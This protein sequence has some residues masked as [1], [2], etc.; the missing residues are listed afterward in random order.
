M[1]ILAELYSMADSSTTAGCIPILFSWRLLGSFSASQRYRIR[2]C[3]MKTQE[4]TVSCGEGLYVN[5]SGTLL[6]G[7]LLH[8]RSSDCGFVSWKMLGS[9]SAAQ[10]YKVHPYRMKT[11]EVAVLCRSSTLVEY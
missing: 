5:P 10:R 8:N 2:L 4:V 6:D 1:L 3:R 9:F 7:R 11:Q